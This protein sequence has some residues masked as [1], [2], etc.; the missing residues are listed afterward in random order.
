MDMPEEAA[1]PNDG[2][3]DETPVGHAG[4]T[5]SQDFKLERIPVPV[6][7]DL[8]TELR[9]VLQTLKTRNDTPTIFSNADHT[10]A[11]ELVGTEARPL[12]R[13]RIAVLMTESC[14]FYSPAK[15]GLQRPRY[16][17]ER[18]TSAV[19]DALP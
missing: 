9:M 16:Q 19:A 3:D 11:V 6:N 14:F 18:L 8:A 12:T 2:T 5:T 4:G 15:G 7:R 13:D 10:A 17:P 1:A